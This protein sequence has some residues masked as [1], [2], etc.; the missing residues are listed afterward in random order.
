MPINWSCTLESAISDIEVENLDL[1]GPT[2][3]SVPGYKKPVQFG[4]ITDIAY[5]RCDNDSEIVVST[6]R[7]ETLLGD[8]AVA[9]HPSDKRYS[10]LRG[11]NIQLWHPFRQEAIPLIF[12][13]A[14][15]PAVGTG[16]VKVTPA[17]SKIDYAIGQRHSIQS[18][19]VINEKGFITDGYGRF[20]GMPRFNARDEILNALGSLGLLRETRP[21]DM[22]LPICS[23][24]GDVLEYLLKP[25]WF[26]R[27]EQ[28]ARSAVEAVEKGQLKVH[29]SSFEN[30]WRQ[31]LLNNQDWCISR[32]LWWGHRIPAFQCQH[33]D[34]SIWVAA[35]NAKEARS[36][37]A[38]QLNVSEDA[39]ITVEHDEDVLDTWFSSALL[40]F[41]SLGWPNSTADLSRYY[42]LDILETGHDIFLFWVAKMVMLGKQLTGRIP[43]KHILLHGI[44]RDAE[45]RKM[46]KSKGNVILPEQIIN[47]STVQDLQSELDK[48]LKAGI[49]DQKEYK[50][51]I[52]NIRKSLPKGIPEC[53]TDALRFTLCSYNI[54]DHFIDFS[55]N[56]CIENKKFFNK[57]WNATKFTLSNCNK[58]GVNPQSRLVLNEANLTEI[59]R[60]ILSRLASTTIK[61]EAAMDEHNFGLATYAL[62]SFLYQNMCDVYL[63]CSKLHLANGE[64]P[65]ASNQCSVLLHCL[66]IG[67][68]HLSH[69]TPFLAKELTKYLPMNTIEFEVRSAV[70]T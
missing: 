59:D 32:Q 33:A 66:A 62:K 29:P 4:Q 23:R 70:W 9:V 47:G 57:I 16:A 41:S 50:K 42:P 14:I 25:Q 27:T 56:Q 40:P 44:I 30:I 51:S 63:E 34:K 36:K 49:L 24:S 58:L 3:V 65:F 19:E 10:E 37:A 46:S 1:K 2:K 15:D 6:T 54:T 60:W 67:I 12:D 68:I 38:K 26:V 53:G 11:Q 13:L 20:S 18:K 69:F 28:M 31:W 35:H 64:E 22:Q 39:D 5:K 55:V 45:G 43:F 48:S 7:P 17:H 8:M 21:H 52:A 61:F